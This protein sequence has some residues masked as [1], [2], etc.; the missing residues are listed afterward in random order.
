MA[1]QN[2]SRAELRR[3]DFKFITIIIII[4][5]VGGIGTNSSYRTETYGL[6][7]GLQNEY[8]SQTY[9]C[10]KHIIDNAAVVRVF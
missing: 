9:G 8:W 1:H 10:I 2:Y 3:T 4:I 5:I 7:A 6:C